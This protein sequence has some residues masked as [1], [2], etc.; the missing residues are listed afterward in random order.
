[1]Q[2]QKLWRNRLIGKDLTY[3][4][5]VY[6]K[7]I[8]GRT[9]VSESTLQTILADIPRTFGEKETFGD[10]IIQQLLMEY[11]TVQAGDCYL[12]GFSYFMSLIWQVFRLSDNAKA[13]SFWCFCKIVGIV[14]PMKPDFNSKWF[15]WNRKCWINLLVNEIKKKR[16]L[17][18]S[19]IDEELEIF[20]SL[21][22]VKWYMLWFSQN[23]VYEEL[24]TL[25]DFLITVPPDK[26]ML[27]YNMIALVIIEQA[28][29]DI[30]YKCDGQSTLVINNILNL[31][32]YNVNNLL[33]LIGP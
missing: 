32:I 20:S 7:Y 21:I 14:R 1:M 4:R 17:L 8:Q 25:W 9:E 27:T 11:A 16:P 12:Q 24:M 6:E 3:K 22:L 23:I 26:L 30:V 19:I 28:A 18:G 29:D 15:D 2:R 33:K 13:D 5:H 10:D 31:K